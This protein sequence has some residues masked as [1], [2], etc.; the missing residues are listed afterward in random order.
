MRD[1]VAA[2]AILLGALSSLTATRHPT[3]SPDDGA[4]PRL[5]GLLPCTRQIE[6]RW[7]WSGAWM[8]PVGDSL[9]L[10]RATGSSPGY[11]VNRGV[12]PHGGGDGHDG[13]DLAN[14][15]AGGGVRAAAS[16]VVVA[17]E[18]SS[19]GGYGS[20][21]VM[22]HR[23]D[24]GSLVYTVYA[25]LSLGSTRVREGAAVGAGDPI[26]RVGQT[27]RASTPHLHFEVRVPVDSTLR[28]EKCPV[29]DPVDFVCDRLPTPRPDSDWAAPYLSWAEF[30]A[31]VPR[32]LN[33]ATPLD[34]ALLTRILRRAGARDNEA[35]EADDARAAARKERRASP[36]WNAVAGALSALSVNPA[37][38]LPC[39]VEPGLHGLMCLQH[40]GVKRPAHELHR[41]AGRGEPPTLGDLCLALADLAVRPARS[42]HRHRR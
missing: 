39:S 6:S 1:S 38:L 17:V 20:Y 34:E 4:A 9:E 35:D 5:A 24:D 28:W 14:G 26:A 29:V 3:G 40:L 37:R 11:Q 30:A 12:L 23:L 16:G 33:A 18:R 21:I 8:F 27:G 2:A 7:P 42:A 22:A 31:L 36:E 32:G 25:H 41:L 15:R 10:G 19:R 13:A